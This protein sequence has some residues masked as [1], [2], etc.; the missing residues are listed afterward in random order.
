MREFY[1]DPLEAA[2]GRLS[3]DSVIDGMRTATVLLVDDQR[4]NLVALEAALVDL[5]CNL[6]AVESG[7]D[8]LRFLLD[9]EAAAVLLDVHMPRL[10]GLETARLIRGRERSR[11]V[12]II[13]VTA[14]EPVDGQL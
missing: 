7:E 14:A 11:N 10:D 6:V 2:H 5:D 9:R 13:F 12:P 1:S 3:F 8:A 4:A